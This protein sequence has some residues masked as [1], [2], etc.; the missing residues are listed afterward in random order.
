MPELTPNQ[1]ETFLLV[2][3]AHVD[4]NYSESEIEF[5][6]SN[7]NEETYHSML[8]LY[9]SL[10]EYQGLK[11][12]LEHSKKDFILQ[13]KQV[14]LYDKI[15]SLFKADGDYSRAEKVFLSFLDKMMDAGI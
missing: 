15:V 8:D 1:F 4:Y 11:V 12:I 7:T 10:S 3:A 13:S 14:E 6:L 9:H 2:Y 5:I